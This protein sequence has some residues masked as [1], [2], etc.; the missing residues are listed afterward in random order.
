MKV[1][2]TLILMLLTAF[3][4][5]AQDAKSEQNSIV[6]PEAYEW[7]PQYV[8]FLPKNQI[9]SVL[10]YAG[11][12]IVP[13][14]FELYKTDIIATPQLDS[15][16]SLINKVDKDPRVKLAYVWVGGSASPDGQLSL[17]IDLAGKRGKALQSYLI[18][19]TS[20]P[21]SL[22]RL[23]NLGEDW[24]TITNA[25]SKSSS[26]YKAQ[27]LKTIAD[28]ADLDQ[29]EMALKSL[30]GGRPW[31]W[32]K[33]N[34]LPQFR[35][36]RL[37]IVCSAEDIDLK[38][39][40][41][42]EL[43]PIEPVKL[44]INQDLTSVDVELHVEVGD[45]DKAK[46]HKYIP[47]YVATVNS[48]SLPVRFVYHV[49]VGDTAKAKQHNYIPPYL[50]QEVVCLDNDSLPVRFVYH[51]E[52]G[53]TAR[54]KQHKYIPPY[55]ATV[56]SDSLPVRFVYH[57]V[58]DS[59]KQ[60]NTEVKTNAKWFLAA[61]TNLLWL[62]GTVANLGFE[63]QIADRWSIDVPVYYSPYDIK[64]YRKIR[65]LATQPELRYWFGAQPG[66]GH[67]MG[68]HGH[69][70][71]FN[72]AIND[73]GRYQDPESPLWGFGLGYGYALNFGK[74]KHWGLEFN[75]GVGFANYKYDEFY[76][77]PNGQLRSTGEDWYWGVTRAGITLTY[78]WWIP[79]KS[80]INKAIVK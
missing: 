23:E 6:P 56:D 3:F 4:A 54:A 75:I 20:L 11:T 62:A 18:R 71:G 41:K 29:R 48:D 74:Y 45:M 50:S 22:V 13:V 52:V 33:Q 55:V 35:N 80:K 1:R 58:F 77:L 26:P 32:M 28:Y 12:D 59:V 70:A 61:K 2:I 69:I 5:S 57:V 64:P 40:E 72:V 34:I 15:I 73:H 51:V 14:K 21:S 79:R 7:Y 47:P 38:A 30:E 24:Y 25:I 17:N 9:D 43:K 46:Q 37:V 16:V 44:P 8:T 31:E 42:V 19:K 68:L 27:I 78:K 39:I 65:V 49:E 76:N 10:Q 36:S 66:E 60:E 53:D 63:A 67:F